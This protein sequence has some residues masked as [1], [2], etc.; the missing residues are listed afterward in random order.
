ME[1]DD[2]SWEQVY[3]LMRCTTK[4]EKKIKSELDDDD[5]NYFDY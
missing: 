3:G 1:F 4:F 5:L 2:N